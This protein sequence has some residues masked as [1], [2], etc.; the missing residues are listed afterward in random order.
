MAQSTPT[1]TRGGAIQVLPCQAIGDTKQAR[2]NNCL[3]YSERGTN[4][5]RVKN[6][7]D[8]V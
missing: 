8:R 3:S 7:D 6:A 1:L 5:E 2:N 4:R